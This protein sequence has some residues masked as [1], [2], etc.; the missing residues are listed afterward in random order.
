MSATQGSGNG[1]ASD[2][3]GDF[4][5]LA[6]VILAADA[7]APGARIVIPSCRIGLATRAILDE[8]QPLRVE[9]EHPRTTVSF[10]MGCA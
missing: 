2:G 5:G 6:K 4:G 7:A 1:G 3:L 10:E 9:I 8:A